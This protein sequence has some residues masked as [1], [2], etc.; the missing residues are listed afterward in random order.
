MGFTSG[1]MMV[2]NI[3]GAP[4]AGWIYDTW[5]TYQPAWFAFAGIALIG[6]VLVFTLPSAG[7][8]TRLTS[9]TA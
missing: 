4:L 1:I 2:G 9:E 5:G 3:S 6:A 7:K 8:G